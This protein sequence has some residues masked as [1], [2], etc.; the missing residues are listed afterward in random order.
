MDNIVVGIIFLMF[1]FSIDFFSENINETLI[2]DILP[3]FVGFMFLW[4]TL[5]RMQ[6]INRSFK[7][8]NNLSVILLVVSFLN[9]ASQILP[10]FIG[11]DISGIDGSYAWIILLSNLVRMLFSFGGS[12]YLALIMLFLA[13]L[14]SAFS[15]EMADKDKAKLY[16]G[17]KIM[18]FVYLAMIVVCIVNQFIEFPVDVWIMVLPVNG[19]FALLVYFCMK[20]I[21]VPKEID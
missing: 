10:I 21:K 13:L 15:D 3:D 6:K 19:I 2:I 1:R 9:F 14:S 7:D 18:V 4:F 17:T 12:V 11:G 5:D 8:A 16:W 20:H